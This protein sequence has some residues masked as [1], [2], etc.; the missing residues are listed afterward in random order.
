MDKQEKVIGIE[1]LERIESKSS[2]DSGD[3]VLKVAIDYKK[4]A[5]RNRPRGYY[6]CLSVY[7]Q[8]DQGSQIH[9]LSFGD[10]GDPTSY[11]LLEETKAFSAKKLA[12]LQVD[13]VLLAERVTQIKAE[14][15][16]RR[17]K[18]EAQRK[19]QLQRAIDQENADFVMH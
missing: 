11:F 18:K 12:S 17:D 7:L 5:Y 3:K 15:V 9:C 4:D 16:R 19:A 13:E 8:T 1:V 14:Y 10:E 6:L 2:W